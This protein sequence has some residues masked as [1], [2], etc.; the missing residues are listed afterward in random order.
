[1]NSEIPQYLIFSADW[2]DEGLWR[3]Y[4]RVGDERD[5]P[6][7][8]CHSIITACNQTKLFR[9][10]H[11]SLHLYCRTRGKVT[12]Q[13]V[14][15]VYKRYLEWKEH[16]APILKKIET[17]DQPLPHIMCLQYGSLAYHTNFM[18]KHWWCFSIQYHTA[19]IQHLSPLLHSPYFATADQE[20]LRALVIF[21]A[22][23]GMEM[24]E[25]CRRL[26][27]SRYL[28]PLVTMCTLHISDAVIRHS[29]QPQNS[30]FARD[31]ILFCFESLQ[32]AGAGFRICGPLQELFRRTVVG[33][34]LSLPDNLED[35]MEPPQNFGVDEILGACTRLEYTQP[36]SQVLNH[37]DPSIGSDWQHYWQSLIMAPEGQ[38]TKPTTTERYLQIPSL[39]NNW[40][41]EYGREEPN[42]SFLIRMN[43]KAAYRL[44]TQLLEDPSKNDEWQVAQCIRLYKE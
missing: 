14:L 29:L 3:F 35:L 6:A 13:A 19:I 10:I 43:A 33:S 5:L 17:N 31:T 16:L 41:Q 23:S 7:R 18:G 15:E 11:E 34:S 30:K 32:E 1:M 12:A 22:Q 27:S 20:S 26:Y 2:A 36:L 40:S 37:I 44:P 39:L 4:R 24:L 21:H 42:F 8:P 28:S 38:F 9:I 25:H